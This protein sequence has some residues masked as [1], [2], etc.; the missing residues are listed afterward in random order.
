MT[1]T[2]II[3]DLRAI[4][5]HQAEDVTLQA[6]DIVDVPTSNGKKFLRGLINGIV[7]TVS[8]ATVRVIP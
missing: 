3:V 6:N 4:K 5:K 7:P 8:R 2:E 1:K